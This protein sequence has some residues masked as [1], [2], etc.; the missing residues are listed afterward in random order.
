MTEHTPRRP[1]NLQVKHLPEH[2]SRELH[3]LAYET[4]R[5]KRDLVIE[6][7]EARYGTK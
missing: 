2:L 7:L 5:T 4:G 6:A 3:R 1:E